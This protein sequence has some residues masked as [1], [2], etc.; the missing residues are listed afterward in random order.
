MP[1][2]QP[3]IATGIPASRARVQLAAPRFQERPVHGLAHER[4]DEGDLRAFD[5]EQAGIDQPIERG[6]AVVHHR[7]Q[8]SS[9]EPETQHRGREQRLA[10]L[11]PEFLD[12]RQHE[13]LHRA[14]HRDCA[15]IRGAQQLVEEKRV[16][17]RAVDAAFHGL[18]RQLRIARRELAR[19]VV[20][21]RREIECRERTT[22]RSRAPGG[23]DRIFI[24][25]RGED[26]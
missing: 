5:C 20:G 12:A 4:V 3:R 18:F 17:L 22:A 6:F 9:R 19:F 25:P 16:A 1:G 7:G 21:E 8:G 11:A 24:R 26:E 13:R 14:R 23:V 2:A 15:R 10:S